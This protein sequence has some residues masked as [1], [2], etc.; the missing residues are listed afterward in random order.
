MVG[1]LFQTIGKFKSAYPTLPLP[2]HIAAMADAVKKMVRETT[3]SGIWTDC[4]TCLAAYH[5]RA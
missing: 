1:R 5:N 4:A 3:F 2:P